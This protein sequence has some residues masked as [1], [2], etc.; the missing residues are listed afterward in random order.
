M[1]E[2]NLYLSQKKI[3]QTL[4]LHHDILKRLI[5]E[6]LKLR[7]I[8]VKWVSHILAASHKLERVKIS[9]KLFGQFNKLQI[10]DLAR[11]ITE[12]ETWTYFGNPRSAMW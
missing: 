8:N 1:T 12:D 3:T 2:V 5:K 11:I 6:E 4:S 7:R 10:N 9:R